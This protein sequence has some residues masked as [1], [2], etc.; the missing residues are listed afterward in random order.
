MPI[1]SVISLLRW[2]LVKTFNAGNVEVTPDLATLHDAHIEVVGYQPGNPGS[3]TLGSFTVHLHPPGTEQYAANK[4][5][6]DQVDYFER[7]EAYISPDGASEG[8]LYYAGIITGIKK[9]F[10]ESAIFELEGRSDIVLA[11]LS[12]PFPGE[13]LSNDVTSA[14]LK[15]YLGTNELGWSDNFNPYTSGNYTST[16]LPGAF[17][18]QAWSGTIDDGFNVVSTT[19]TGTTTFGV[20]LARTGFAANDRWHTQYVECTGRINPSADA[21]D[22]GNFGV[23]ISLS[24]ANCNDCI[25]GYV[26]P[27]KT[28]G[29]YNL[30]S[31]VLRYTGGT[32]TVIINNTVTTLSAV[33]DPQGLIPLTV[34]LLCTLGGNSSGT[35]SVSLTFNGKVVASSVASGYDPGTVTQYPFLF[36][37]TPSTG[38]STNYMTNLVQQTRFT[39]DGPSTAATFGNGTITATTHS[40]AYGTDPG[41]TFL[42]TLAKFATRENYYLR[43]TPKSYVVG[44]RTLGIIDFSI[45]P[46]TNH[47]T[48]GSV[49]FSEASGNLISL[50]LTA[51][52]DQFSAGTTTA[53]QSSSDGGGIGFWRDISTLQKYGVIQ[54][55]TL[56]LTAS[57]FNTARRAA[58]SITSN[59]INIGIAGSKTVQVLRDPQTAD[60]W[61]ELDKVMLHCPSLGINYLVA[62]VISYTF[63]E[64]KD[65]QTLVLDQFSVEDPR[66]TLP[67]KR[68]QQAMFQAAIKFGN[69]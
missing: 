46:G 36:Y 61:R 44:A 59:K 16:H 37:D 65:T 68:L 58:F 31:T 6:Y 43:Y 11:N 27:Y 10:G 12:A 21:T 35:A 22:A 51:N 47:G 41:P 28:G 66:Q 1:E 64:G 20:L 29:R 30:K 23:G 24:N 13:L 49:I 17:A 60:N 34:G 53:T 54:D 39:T 25:V 7:L 19:G 69:R 2:R 14:I 48:D 40:L 55:Q 8:K 9:T 15:S 56:A 57:D 4:A 33:D 45:D 50:S 67:L 5:I 63:D 32:Q 62:R 3:T 26:V 52:G 18:G 42:E 38:T